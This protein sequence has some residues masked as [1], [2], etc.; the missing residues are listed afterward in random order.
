MNFTVPNHQHDF[1][2]VSSL[3]GDGF[4]VAANKRIEIEYIK[5]PNFIS[6]VVGHPIKFPLIE[7]LQCFNLAHSW[8]IRVK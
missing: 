3:I 8:E 1:I 2:K 4:R 6:N 7:I 5:M